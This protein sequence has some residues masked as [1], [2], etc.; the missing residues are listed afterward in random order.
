[1]TTV[2][3][4]NPNK[5]TLERQE[6]TLN[7]A[8]GIYVTVHG[9]FYQPP[10][11]NPYLNAIERQPSAQPFHDWNER[12]FHEC[13]RNNVYA[14]IYNDQGQIVGIVNNF[15]YLSFNIGATLMSWLEKYD[16]EIYQKITEADRASCERLNGHGNAIAQVYNHIILPLANERDKYTQ[17]RWGIT[18]FYQRFGRHPEGMWLAETAVDYPTLGVLIDEGIKFIILAPSQ[19]KKCRPMNADGTTGEWLEVGGGQIDPTR[20]YRCYVKG[21][22][23]ID[24]FFYDGPI[25]GDMGFGDVLSSSHNFYSR[26]KLAVRGD[27]RQSQL[28]SVATDGETFGHHKRDTERCI[29]YAFTRE[30]PQQG[31]NVTNYAHYL[32]L[33]E[34]TWEVELKSVTAWSC[35]HGVDRWQDDCGCGGGGGFHQKWRRPLRDSLNWLRDELTKVY[36]EVAP[37]Y[38]ADIWKAR[39]EYVEVI[40][41]RSLEN[42]ERFL[43]KHSPQSLPPSEQ[44]DALRLLE[45]QRHSLLMFTS[46]GWFFE[47]ISRPEGTQIL[48]Y[49]SRAIELAGEISGIQL[50][51]QFIKR[52]K[53]APSNVESFGDGGEVY[54]QSVIPNQITLKQVAAHYA[55]SSLYTNYSTDETIYCYDAHQLDYQKQQ[56]GSLTLAVGQLKLTSQITWE[57]THYVFG[58]I[59]LG[60]WDFHCCIQPF[61]SRLAYSQIKSQL[62]SALKDMSVVEVI[63]LMS[64]LFGNQS[65][66]LQQI[67]GEERLIIR[68]R[69]METTKKH[70][71]QLYTQVYRDNYSIL[72]AYYR[73]D[74]PVPQELQVAAQVAIS[75][76][77]TQVI[78]ELATKCPVSCNV[79]G[80]LM[81][82][83]AIALEADHLNCKLEVPEAKVTLEKLMGDFLSQILDGTSIHTIEHD[84]DT[85]KSIIDIGKLLKI[86]LCLNRAQ[87]QLYFF[88]HQKSIE[89]IIEQEVS[90]PH[91]P[92][93]RSLFKLGEYLSV[94]CGK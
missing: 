89:S 57:S 64:D 23:H 15:E 45:M 6:N 37:S 88:V 2:T 38:F 67:F 5:L 91:S 59:H 51:K 77:C 52:L 36:K 29:A 54:L 21:H 63:L 44:V 1:M 39:D 60:G 11:E 35:S 17:V 42:V 94:Y 28:I 24:I 53:K 93:L 10:R 19:A 56:I 86:D 74:V 66:D 26:L 7:T 46:C 75:Y 65:F 14:R 25:S 13:Y 18:D 34:P 4:I 70:L 79:E 27:E 22:G 82:L 9:H 47:E 32:S 62:F 12:I 3:A 8:T 83:E 76:R 50:E 81:E 20:P 40:L 61:T 16:R 71:D 80:Y 30:F 78:Q 58:V 41:D 84:I 68:D 72:L 49:A 48:R 43:A 85:I 90:M 55:I 87:E 73:D 33:V 31:W 92:K 69:L